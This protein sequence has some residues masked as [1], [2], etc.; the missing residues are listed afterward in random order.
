MRI[1]VLGA[2]GNVGRRIVA[3]ALARGHEVTAIVRDPRQ[4]GDIPAR[5][6]ARVAD[7]ASRTDVATVSADQ[8]VVICAT[9][10]TAGHEEVIERTTRCVLDGVGAS[11][12]RLIIVGG[13]ATLTVPGAEGR[14]VLQDPRYLPVSARPVAEAS[15]RQYEICRAES[16]VDWAYLSPAADL[17]SGKRTGKYRVGRDELLV[18]GKGNSHISVEDLAVA[19]LDEAERPRHHRERFTVAY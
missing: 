1:A 16:R 5:A 12:A 10:P 2:R 14:T 4:L 6:E 17:S 18:D 8:D 3:E 7:A 19:L 9:R 13:A 11:R 15:A